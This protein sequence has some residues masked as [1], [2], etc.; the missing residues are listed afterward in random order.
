MKILVCIK[1]VYNPEFIESI[2]DE[3]NVV[4][5]GD[6]TE[7]RINRFDE[8]ALEEALKIKDMKGAVT[9][10]VITV[11]D[12]NS[13]DVIKRALGMGGDRGI[14]I[15][16]DDIELSDPFA[17]ATLLATEAGKKKYDL[18]LTGIMSEDMMNAQTGQIL[19]E[20]LK[21]SCS[22]AVVKLIAEPGAST[23]FAEREVEGG[24]RETIETA[25]PVL[26]TIQ[27]GINIPR[28][29]TLSNILNADSKEVITIKAAGVAA[30]QKVISLQF[31]EKLRSGLFLSGNTKEK[32]K[33]L[34]DIL[35]ERNALKS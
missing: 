7:Y 12:E 29:P 30:K 33:Q 31:P 19:A 34:Y 32:A 2:D 26:F 18:I 11:G 3:N 8:Y 22:S 35:K 27:A 1:Q 28:Y 13:S 21:I 4:I 9:V 16:T 23:V 25:L 15:L 6:N 5:P 17:T 14:H 10:D 24:I 20:L